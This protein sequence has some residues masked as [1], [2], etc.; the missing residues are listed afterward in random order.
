[1][2]GQNSRLKE[3]DILYTLGT[4]LVILLWA[5]FVHLY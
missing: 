3:I 1:M 2:I 5:F 4:I